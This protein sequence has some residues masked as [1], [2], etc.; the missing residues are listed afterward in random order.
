[1]TFMGYLQVTTDRLTINSEELLENYV[2][3]SGQILIK[4]IA[5]KVKAPINNDR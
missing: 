3:K 1:M 2:I 4:A 5:W